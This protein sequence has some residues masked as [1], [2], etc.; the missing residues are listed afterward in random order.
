MP[1]VI[2]EESLMDQLL[3]ELKKRIKGIPSTT[4]ERISMVSRITLV[5]YR[6]EAML[7][8][9]LTLLYA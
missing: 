9:A 4:D 7:A 2:E 3:R 8:F 1:I 6:V 5:I